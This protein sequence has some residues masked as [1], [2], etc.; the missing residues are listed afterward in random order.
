[1]NFV[2]KLLIICLLV[3]G[4]S[5][6]GA[7]KTQRAPQISVIEASETLFSSLSKE[8]ELLSELLVAAKPTIGAPYKWGGTHLTKG[9]DCSNYTWQLCRKVGSGYERF[10]GTQVMS[11]LNRANG[12]KKIAFEDA[13]AG[14]LLVYG[15]RDEK[16]IWRGHVVILMDRDGKT[17]GHKGLALGAHGGG[18]DSV[19]FITY[20]GF[21]EGYYMRPELKI[22]NVLR[23]EPF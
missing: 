20:R 2:S 22:R 7:S 5:L 17:T 21:E 15:Y 1:M 13:Q 8:D 14:D 10:L 11:R 23:L 9:I 12:L 19:Q 6:C 3:S 18:V 4:A 16:K